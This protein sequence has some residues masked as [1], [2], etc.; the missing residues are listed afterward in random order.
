M[1]RTLVSMTKTP[2]VVTKRWLR[3]LSAGC[4]DKMQNGDCDGE[5]GLPT[6]VVPLWRAVRI[7]ICAH[8]CRHLKRHVN[9]HVGRRLYVDMSICSVRTDMV[10]RRA[11]RRC[12]GAAPSDHAS[13]KI[14]GRCA[15]GSCLGEVCSDGARRARLHGMQKA[16]AIADVEAVSNDCGLLRLSVPIHASGAPGKRRRASINGAPR[17]RSS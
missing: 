12:D 8:M 1:M 5:R 17:W 3:R 16:T 14:H 13:R 7:D 15:A 11:L 2:A 10:G 4:G 6:L 9:I